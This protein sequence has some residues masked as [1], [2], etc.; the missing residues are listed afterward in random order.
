VCALRTFKF[1]TTELGAAVMWPDYETLTV[2]AMDDG[3]RH[4]IVS[5]TEFASA[6]STAL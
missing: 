6:L 4:S 2:A 3:T 1:A 5:N